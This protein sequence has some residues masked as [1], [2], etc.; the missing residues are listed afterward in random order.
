M[1]AGENIYKKKMKQKERTDKA[2]WF[3]YKKK[4]KISIFNQQNLKKEKI[5]FVCNLFGC[6]K[7]KSLFG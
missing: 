3:K 4:K 2:L 6:K 5:E 1:S 7:K